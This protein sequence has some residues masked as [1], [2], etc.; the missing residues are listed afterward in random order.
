MKT[1]A[2]KKTVKKPIKKPAAKKKPASKK[3]S[4]TKVAGAGGNGKERKPPYA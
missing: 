1:T 4:D 3:K 2:A